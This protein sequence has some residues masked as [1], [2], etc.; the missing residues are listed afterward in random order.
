[1]KRFVVLF[2][3]SLLLIT[4]PGCPE[5]GKKPIPGGKPEEKS[6]LKEVLPESIEGRILFHSIRSGNLDIYRIDKNGVVRLTDN[7]ARDERPVWSPDGTKIAFISDRDGNNEIYLMDADGENQRRVTFNEWDDKNPSWSPDGRSIVFESKRGGAINLYI[8]DLE[9]YRERKLTDYGLRQVAGIPSWSPDGGHIAFTSNKWFGYNV[10]IITVDGREDK[11][12]TE[13]GGS[14]GPVWSPNG[15]TIAFVN[16][17]GKSR[18]WL[19]DGDGKNKRQL[20][21]GPRQY[22]YNPAW[23]PDGRKIAYMSTDDPYDERRGEIFVLDILS[24]ER[25]QI[26]YKMAGSPSWHE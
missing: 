11:R 6:A 8:I 26:T 3:F 19:M 2:I 24:G 18:I 1:M 14:C 21:N 17:N 5:R 13:K 15:K 10:S 16:R 22:D 4:F 20:T 9:T 23:S 12:L 25:T 7:P